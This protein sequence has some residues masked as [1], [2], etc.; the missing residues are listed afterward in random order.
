[1]R[2]MVRETDRKMVRVLGQRGEPIPERG[3]QSLNRQL[4]RQ[5][6][7]CVL[8]TSGGNHREV[9]LSPQEAKS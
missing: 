4:S 8:E 3:G 5:S 1:M 7:S 9:K 6:Q 2:S